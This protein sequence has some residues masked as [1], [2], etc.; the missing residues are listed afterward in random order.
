MSPRP[1][2]TGEKRALMST[3]TFP[4]APPQVP[5]LPPQGR[6]SKVAG[7]KPDPGIRNPSG[8]WVG[9]F[10]ITMSFAAFTSALFVRQGSGDWV[11][12]ELPRLIYANTGV[13]LLSSLTLEMARRAFVAAPDLEAGAL[14]NS[15]RWLG[16]TLALGLAFV[17]GQYF[18]WR[19]LAAQGLYLATNSNS[20]FL[21][22][23]TAVHAMH[24]LGGITGLVR[25]TVRMTRKQVT[26]RRSSVTNTVIYWH[27]MGVLWLY[28]LLVITV[29]L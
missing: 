25:L 23:L 17:T 7:T 1:A 12:V 2:R 18:V 22:V 28:L 4:T 13:L 10:A 9:I 26:L 19:E 14:R 11:H 29:R 3:T 15:L 24:V 27:F 6:A 5:P 21:Y 8:I 20:S 16:V